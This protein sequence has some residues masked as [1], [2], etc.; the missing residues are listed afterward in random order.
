VVVV[1]LVLCS[2]ELL[3]T[4]FVGTSRHHLS[5]PHGGLE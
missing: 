4:E 1:V 3:H 5:T 2:A